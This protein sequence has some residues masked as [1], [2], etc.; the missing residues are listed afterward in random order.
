MVTN[1]KDD[2]EMPQFD[3]DFSPM[4]P[5]NREAARVRRLRFDGQKGQYVGSGGNPVRDRFGQPY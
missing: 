2:G 3:P 5:T 4:H 1:K